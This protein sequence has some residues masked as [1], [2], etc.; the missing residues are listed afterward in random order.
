MCII[1]AIQVTC[2][3]LRSRGSI[4]CD[5]NVRQASPGGDTPLTGLAIPIAGFVTA[6]NEGTA[7]TTRPLRRSP[8]R[9]IHVENTTSIG[10][11]AFETPPKSPTPGDSEFESSNGF[12]ETEMPFQTPLNAVFD[13]DEPKDLQGGQPRSPTLSSGGS[14]Q[15]GCA[16]PTRKCLAG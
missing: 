3:C 13:N 6:R 5:R 1:R 14:A 4:D 11:P 15:S 10:V 16:R 7:W 2:C 9:S 12:S 8:S